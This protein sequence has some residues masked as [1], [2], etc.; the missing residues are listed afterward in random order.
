VVLT[1]LV[2]TL[3][4]T[5]AGLPA[6][7]GLASSS[8]TGTASV[9]VLDVVMLVD[10][11]GSETPAKVADEKQT[12]G[13]IVQTM[14]NPASRVTVIGFGGVNAP[15]E[16]QVDVACQP[17]IAS[18]QASLDYLSSCV[19]KLH[20]RTEQEGDDTDYAAALN[21]AMS[22]LSPNSTATPASP[23]NA[24][25]VILMMTDGAVDVHRD[26]Q[27][28]GSDWQLGEQT[29]INQQ[30][31]AAKADSVQL[32]PLGFGADVGTNLTQTQAKQ[33]LN[34]MASAGS[35]AV[36][37][38]RQAAN[39]PHATW[40]NDP[41]DA[42]NA[43]NQLYADAACLGSTTD[44][45]P[46][47]H[48]LRVSIPAIASS[49]AISVDRVNPAI[50]VSFI[51]PDGSAWTD[52][53]A[54]SGADGN[55]PV[56]V[57]HLPGITGADIGTWHIKLTAPASLASQLVSATV[58]WQGAVRAIITATPSVNPGQQIAVKLTVLGPSGPI[59]DS[60]ALNGL[61]VGVTAD[62][63][64]FPS[65]VGIPMT[66][67]SGSNDVGTYAGSYTAPSQ[68]TTVTI[69]GIASGYGLY[70]TK[71]PA[72]VSVGSASEGFVATPHFPGATSIG[73]GGTLTGNIDFTN[74]TGSAKQVL[75]KLTA[76]GTTAS[77]S[78]STPIT[79]P[80]QASGS[81]PSVPFT[82]SIDKSARAGLASLELQAVDA[83]T[84]QVYNTVADE[85]QVTTPPPWYVRYLW[86]LIL[87]LALLLA[88]VV[89]ALVAR[90]VS[91]DRKNVR[92]LAVTLRRG[93]AVL[94]RELS[95][96]DKKYDEVFQFF[97]RDAATSPRLSY[98]PQGASTGLYTIRRAGRGLVRLT[99]P[100]GL[101]PYEVE[102]GG[103]AQ[104]IDEGFEVSVKDTRHPHGVAPSRRKRHGSS[105]RSGGPVP[106]A[107][108]GAQVPNGYMPTVSYQGGTDPSGGG[109]VPTSGYPDAPSFP[110]PPPAAPTPAQPLASN[111]APYDQGSAP[112]MPATPP[113]TYEPPKNPWI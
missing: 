32:W 107:A 43:L 35:P 6:R 95:A 38:T 55:S 26:T 77:V 63:Q 62:G 60:S 98:P 108:A 10:E 8:G 13:T 101:R 31:S 89:A 14:L 4:G 15:G 73:A 102:V 48:G 83:D 111:P 44:T 99:T 69:T 17:T 12:A 16:S 1:T 28:Y 20:R 46:A 64:E 66:A 9:A 92:G 85:V 86:L 57:L 81:L 93:G 56:E 23:A 36:C 71:F 5:L 104:E 51:A 78:P 67:L 74:Q 27:Q 96:P 21:E 113:S 41:T 22:Y 70:A 47:S 11:S 110:A 58:F 33:Y 97:I 68:P 84:G 82:V 2:V 90:K 112:T 18:G 106:T 30:M 103:S 45:E 3:L 24:I 34:N 59:I 72:T 91:R 39:Q 94:G 105:G 49:A 25:K 50:S 75:L 61:Q 87:I 42:I 37:N 29:A 52:A 79:V 65:P 100:V 54:I 88:A 19:G 109:Y 40:V 7:A 80:S 53:A 76:D